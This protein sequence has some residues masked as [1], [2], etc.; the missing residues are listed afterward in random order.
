[1]KLDQ[2]AEAASAS[3]HAASGAALGETFV[4]RLCG[5]ACELIL[6]AMVI[7]VNIEVVIRPFDLTLDMVDEVGGYL[8]VALTF[9]ALPAALVGNAFHRVEFV[10]ARLSHAGR[11][12]THIAFTAAALVFALMLEWQFL[13]LVGRSY[14]SQVVAPTILGTPVWIPQAAMIVGTTCLIYSLIRVL[15]RA[16]GNAD[17]SR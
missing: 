3:T 6:V 4:E 2:G 17:S 8:L 11:R 12:W 10:Q 14:T 1:M 9:I 16:L 7:L 15:L 5:A 13:R